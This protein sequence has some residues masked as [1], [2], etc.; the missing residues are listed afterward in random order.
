MSLDKSILHGKENRK[1]YYGRTS[2]TFDW[3]CRNH[4]RCSWCRNNR[5]FRSTAR[6]EA[7]KEQIKDYNKNNL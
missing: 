1:P 5:L 3:T 4:G 7:C 2:K 6:K